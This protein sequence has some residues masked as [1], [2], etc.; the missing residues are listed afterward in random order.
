MPMSFLQSLPF[1]LDDAGMACAAAA[2]LLAVKLGIEVAAA[3]PVRRRRR[4]LG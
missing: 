3:W 4:R 2:L 1:S